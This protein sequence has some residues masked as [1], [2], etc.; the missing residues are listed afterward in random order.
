M[1]NAPGASKYALLYIWFTSFKLLRV[2]LHAFI[3]QFTIICSPNRVNMELHR[4]R[5]NFGNFEQCSVGFFREL[6]LQQFGFGESIRNRKSIV[7]H[8]KA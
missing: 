2:Q 4:E 6:H 5:I 1:F 3:E 8:R 7:F